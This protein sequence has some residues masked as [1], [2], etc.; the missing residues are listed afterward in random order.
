[1]KAN[2]LAGRDLMIGD[3]L[4]HANGTP[5]QVKR[6]VF[7]HFACGEKYTNFWEYNNT[8]QPILLTPEILEKN[9]FTLEN[10]VKHPA[11]YIYNVSYSNSVIVDFDCYNNGQGAIK[12]ILA[13]VGLVSNSFIRI[14][15]KD[16]YVHQLQHAL[17]ACGIDKEIII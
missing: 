17:K 3:W 15:G 9:G 6:I 5:M 4:M 16:I 14:Y 11:R 13:G 10:K 12:C 1:M 2:E 7:G 8:F